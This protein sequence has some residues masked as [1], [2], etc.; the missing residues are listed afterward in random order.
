MQQPEGC[1]IAGDGPSVA[2][3]TRFQL[4][5]DENALVEVLDRVP[6]VPGEL[7][8]TDASRD[9]S[10]QP[11]FGGMFVIHRRADPPDQR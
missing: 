3:P 5:L 2:E 10:E 1:L 7:P 8:H 6:A 4:H 9:D 11:G